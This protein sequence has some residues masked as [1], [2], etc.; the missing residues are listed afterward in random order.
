[1]AEDSLQNRLEQLQNQVESLNHQLKIERTQN[2]HLEHLLKTNSDE[3]LTNTLMEQKILIDNA[4]VGMVWLRDRKI[5][6]TNQKMLNI[7]GY[8]M[9]EIIGQDTAIVYNNPEDYIMFGKTAYPILKE[10]KDFQIELLMKRK[11]GSTLWCRFFGSLIDLNDPSKG[12]IWIIYDITEEIKAKKQL[13]NTLAEQQII[14][15]NALVGIIL[16]KNQIITRTNRKFNEILG[17]SEHEIIGQNIK[18]LYKSEQDLIDSAKRVF[19]EMASGKS[20]QVEQQMKRKDGSFIW[21]RYFGRFYKPGDITAGSIWIFQDI[22]EEIKATQEL[23]SQKNLLQEFF[24]NTFDGIILH[25]NGI[26]VEMNPT[27]L[28]MFGY[29]QSDKQQLIGTSVL[30]LLAEQSHD[31]IIQAMKEDAIRPY[32]NLDH[33]ENH[34]G[35]RKDGS[36]FHILIMGRPFQY[37]GKNIRMASVVDITEKLKAEQEL[38]LAK[39]QADSANKAKSLFLANMSHELRTPLNAI[40]GY[41]QILKRDKSLNPKQIKGIDIIENSGNHLLNLIEDILDI[42]KIE[43]DVLELRLNKIKFDTI[44]QSIVDMMVIRATAKQIRFEHHID[45]RLNTFVYVDEK[46]IRQILINLL[47]NAIKFTSKGQISLNV[48]YLNEYQINDISD[49]FK[50]LSPKP[51]HG[52]H[53]LFTIQDTGRGI[54]NDQ[55]K[56]IFQPFHQIIG[57]ETHID[58]A[59]L[60]LSISQRLAN[61]MSSQIHVESIVDQGSKFWF[62][63][64]L[65]IINRLPEIDNQNEKNIIAYKGSRKKILIVDDKENNREFLSDIL[66]PLG[67]E[68]TTEENGQSAL[69]RLMKSSVDLILLD[70]VMPQMDGH[71]LIKNLQINNLIKNM[72]IVI[73]TASAFYNSSKFIQQIANYPCLLKPIKIMELLNILQS[74]LN[75]EWIYESSPTKDIGPEQI[76]FPDKMIITQLIEFLDNGNLTKLKEIL[77]DLQNQQEFRG[78]YSKLKK[79]IDEYLF[80]QAKQFIQSKK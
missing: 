23:E 10:G 18:I 71:E 41:A 77:H 7:F 3:H 17:Y 73:I 36:F 48:Q 15:D 69:N 13:T 56:Q 33:K 80:K 43:S 22:S 72:K 16:I 25:N 35:K 31:S 49:N 55:L 67:F 40:L 5:I 78:F 53:V 4:L 1:M 2:T 21:C 34:I 68:C 76:I 52:I 57:S 63:L 27:F 50:N 58:G 47:G 51:D 61:I 29:Q 70:L 37:H 32:F 54:P 11:D 19:T 24:N 46:R 42:S 75:L 65:P 8:T 26:A 38:K 28:K 59:G 39:E 79:Y 30:D 66:S 64:K 6:R 14:L 60:G 74:Q 9:D 62:E 44:L 12:S 45:P 20:I